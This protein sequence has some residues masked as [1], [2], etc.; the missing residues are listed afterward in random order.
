M[1]T[2]AGLPLM[3][4]AATSPL[5]VYN[6]EETVNPVRQQRRR[7]VAG[8]EGLKLQ[9][10][11]AIHD[12][13]IWVRNLCVNVNMLVVRDASYKQEPRKPLQN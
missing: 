3:A 4:P 9:A 10:A 5:A 8:F 7:H 13:D 6:P 2:N 1:F 12:N 11:A